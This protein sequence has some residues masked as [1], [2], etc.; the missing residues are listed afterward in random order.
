MNK[1]LVTANQPNWFNS[2]TTAVVMAETADEA[3]NLML[4]H[5]FMW[6]EESNFKHLKKI[7]DQRWNSCFNRDNPWDNSWLH[8]FVEPFEEP[9]KNAPVTIV[10]AHSE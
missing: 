10:N 3:C 9:T 4:V 7:D 2:E 6:T 5:G 1:W 8:I